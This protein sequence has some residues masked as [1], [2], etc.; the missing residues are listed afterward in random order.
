MR[1]LIILCEPE[2]APDIRRGVELLGHPLY[3]SQLIHIEE[4]D[5]GTDVDRASYGRLLT[6][7]VE[8][9]GK[10][11]PLT[12]EPFV[13]ATREVGNRLELSR[14]KKTVGFEYEQT[15]A[16]LLKAVDNTSRLA[17]YLSLCNL[18]LRSAANAMLS[19][20]MHDVV[21]RAAIDSWIRQ[22][23]TLGQPNALG[24]RLLGKIYLVSSGELGNRLSKLNPPTSAALCVNSY[25]RLTGK[26]ADVISAIA[27]KREL[28]V[29]DCPAS[30]IDEAGHREVY[31]IED[32]LWSGT[33]AMGVI[34][35][36]RGL[37][38]KGREKTTPLT[39]PGVLT[40]VQLTM[41]YAIGTNYGR[42]SLE[43]HL[44]Q[45]GL[46]TVRVIT[47]EE[48]D[49]VT[50]DVIQRI[51]RG[52]LSLQDLKE[53][54]GP[55]SADILAPA[56]TALR[57]VDELNFCQSIG[58]QLFAHYLTLQQRNPE[59]PWREWSAQRREACALGMHGLGSM[60]LF[61]HSAPK[62][63]L[64]LIWG[65]G[66]VTWKHRSIDWKPLIK[67]AL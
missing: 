22:F 62:A 12:S 9:L 58:Q 7:L 24:E 33:E 30:A 1:P 43:R 34:D 27:R 54:G 55:P 18:T 52:D 42:A 2:H 23:V 56:A 21:T 20:W 65:S 38:Q 60:Q 36:L 49:I 10:G 15:S 17:K 11:Y 50:E 66:R 29:Y 46:K 5:L 40:D 32:G 45:S 26:S 47:L 63:V 3:A 44:S 37:R 35:S 16:T 13:C 53:R 28:K 14:T 57:S 59:N 61:A 19:H 64:P 51:R 48:H 6:H 4:V 25:G 39:N 8:D 31:L 41:A 67:N